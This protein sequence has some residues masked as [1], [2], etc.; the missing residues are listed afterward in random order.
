LESL[1]ERCAYAR[2]REYL[3][4]DLRQLV[5]KSHRIVFAVEKKEKRVTLSAC[6]MSVGGLLVSPPDIELKNSLVGGICGL[7]SFGEP[8]YDAL[9]RNANEYF[10]WPV[11]SGAK[12]I[13]L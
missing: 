4:A 1:P 12:P 8:S 7:M 9:R 13:I 2:E 3:D 6:D 11:S 10:G 5:F